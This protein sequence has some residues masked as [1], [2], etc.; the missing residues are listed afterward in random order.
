MEKIILPIKTKIAALW[1]IMIGIMGTVGFVLL[2]GEVSNL[3]GDWMLK[4]MG[5]IFL[6]LLNFL[7]FLSMVLFFIFKK[8]WIRKINVVILALIIIVGLFTAFTGPKVAINWDCSE[9]IYCG[10]FWE[11]HFESVILFSI[12]LFYIPPFL[13]FSTGR[14]NLIKN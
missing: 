13:L 6:I 10:T 2:P 1:G 14:K 9:V 11:R 12:L 3:G 8:A 7:L 4:G 5:V